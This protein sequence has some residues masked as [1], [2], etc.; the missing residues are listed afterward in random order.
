[1]P[2]RQDL[3]LLLKQSC[4]TN[5]LMP[6]LAL[7]SPASSY[8]SDTSGIWLPNLFT[9]AP[10]V[11]LV[12]RAQEPGQSTGWPGVCPVYIPSC[13]CLLSPV[14]TSPPDTHHHVTQ[15]RRHRIS[16]AWWVSG[17]ET[18]KRKVAG[19]PKSTEEKV[20]IDVP[21]LSL[22]NSHKVTVICNSTSILSMDKWIVLQWLIVFLNH[23]LQTKRG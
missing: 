5:R 15:D 9:R 21:F 2:I 20:L 16:H 18:E 19:G 1:M 10:S 3:E 23:Y 4:Y 22:I 12:R 13:V 8:T 17:K 14:V 6:S 11:V 7:K